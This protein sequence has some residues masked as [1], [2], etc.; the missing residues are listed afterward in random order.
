MHWNNISLSKKILFG[1]GSVL[2]ILSVI[3]L[4]S[5]QSI[6]ELVD[7]GTQVVSG[8]RL[9]SEILQREIDHLNW[10]N[11]VGSFLNSEDP[12]VQLTVQLDHTKCGFGKWFYG[13][14]RRA[15]E[16]QIP[17]LKPVFEA[18]DAPHQKLHASA[19]RIKQIYKPADSKLP[20]FLTR[21]EVDHLLWAEKVQQAIFTQKQDIAVQLDPT[22][23]GLGVFLHGADGDAMAQHDS[24][25]AAMLSEITAPHNRLH[26]GG[27]AVK[28]ALEAKQFDRAR[29]LYTE[30][31]QPALDEVRGILARMQ[32]RAQENL[33]AGVEAKQIFT[34][35]TQ[36]QLTTV[37]SKLRELVKITSANM[38]SENVMLENAVSARSVIIAVSLTGAV[39]GLLLAFIIARS[40]TRPIVESIDLAKT[41]ASGDLTKRLH[42]TRTDEAGQLGKSLTDMSHQLCSVVVEVRD[43]A[44]VVNT[45]SAEL[46]N[47]ATLLSQ[48]TS[49]Q[50]AAVAEIASTMSQI[51][52]HIQQSSDNAQQ[53]EQI[54]L[55]TARDA[56]AGGQA[57]TEAVTAMNEIAD[58]I[59]IIEEIA[60]Q[61]NLLALNAAI[62]AARAGEHGKG[63]AVVAAEVRKLAERSQIAAG[64]IGQISTQSVDTAARAGAIIT[65]LVPD[66]QKIA[67]L[68]QEITSSGRNQAH[69]IDQVNAS[70]Q[71][72][73]RSIQQNAGTSEELAATSEELS[74]QSEVLRSLVAFFV[75][76]CLPARQ[77]RGK[78]A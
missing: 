33:A 32:T 47:S 59:S 39:V 74:A 11:Q 31:I 41:I 54:S 25:L 4:W 77:Q 42:V 22:K 51:A 50:A 63:F 23:C 1:I 19:G 6:S 53:T 34:T 55:K 45:G 20:M 75:T 9:R 38:I 67:G 69:D 29:T 35:E 58:K 18:I 64:Q 48:S 65:H 12:Q 62:E 27:A 5:I 44:D 30:S 37:Q 56:V 52:N 68:I 14:E 10:A 70:F 49:E 61:T 2:F 17:A 24:V 78:N 73:E 71:G 15:A 7:D 76:D 36:P 26:A 16:Q 60:R 72:L 3:S 46:S 28:Q 43:T 13:D 21:R 57:V 66:I 8:N 40:I